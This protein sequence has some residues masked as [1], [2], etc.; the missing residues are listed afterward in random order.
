MKCGKRHDYFTSALPWPQKNADGAI[1]LPLGTEAPIRGLG[2]YSG[3]TPSSTGGVYEYNNASNPLT[4]TTGG[5]VIDAGGS[6]SGNQVK[7]AV[8]FG[9]ADVQDPVI[10]ADLTDATAATI[11][12]IRLAFQTQKLYERDARGGTR[13]TEIVHSHFGVDS[14]DSRLQRP[15]YLGGGSAPIQVIP[16]AQTTQAA[17][18]FLP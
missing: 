17:N 8:D 7:M 6:V 13:Y 14:P 12:D 2:V 11:N 9:S 4:Y 5:V 10:Y 3:G 1:S 18:L 16:V 15:E